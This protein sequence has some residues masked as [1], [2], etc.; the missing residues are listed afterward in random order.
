M[1]DPQTWSGSGLILTYVDIL[2]TSKLTT[3]AFDEWWIVE[4]VPKLVDT[5]AITWSWAYKAANPN[6]EKQRVYIYKVSD[7]AQVHA[8]VLMKIPRISEKGY[9][10]GDLEA[11]QLTN[12]ESRIY[13]FEQLYETSKNEEG[14]VKTVY[15]NPNPR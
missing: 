2:D 10:E 15:N 7:L 1:A 13:S 5:G 4:V 14:K 3:E 6:N 12:Y 8:G 11:D 9:F